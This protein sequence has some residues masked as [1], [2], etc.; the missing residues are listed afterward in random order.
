VG[1]IDQLP[2]VGPGTVL[3][4]LIGSSLIGV[5]RLTEIFRQARGSKII[6]NAH[7]INQGE[8][9]LLDTFVHSDFHYIEA[10]TPEAIKEIILHLVN[11]EIPTRWKLHPLDE[12]QVLSPM[13]KGIIGVEMLNDALQSLLNPSSQPLFRSGRR[14]HVSDK[15]MQIR[16]DYDK[17]V[18]NG[19]IGKIIAI[20]AAQQVL[21][22]MFDDRT[23]EYDFT[24]LDDLVLAYATSV[25]KFQGSECP[26][27][28]LPIHTSHFKLLQR[29]LLYTA[30]TRGKKQVYLVGTKKAIGIAIHNDQV[31]KRYTGLEAALREAS[32]SSPQAPNEQLIFI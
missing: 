29:N 15:V 4:D 9:P 21:S 16:N 5:T 20:D 12:I 24:E 13:K 14:F 28:I 1:D 30:V 25:H 10:E 26:C 31:Q 3:R 27:I 11:R 23:L 22:V 2:S 19:D 18:Y 17:N 32:A 8:F 7:R 6:T